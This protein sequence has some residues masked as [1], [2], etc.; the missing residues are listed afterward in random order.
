MLE[1][2]RYLGDPVSPCHQVVKQ[3]DRRADEKQDR[4][5]ESG[6]REGL[7]KGR[8]LS[9]H[10][11]S[12]ALWERRF[13]PS[14]DVKVIAP[15]RRPHRR[16]EEGRMGKLARLLDQSNEIGRVLRETDDLDLSVLKAQFRQVGVVGERLR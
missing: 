10:L 4:G 11:R 5:D 7:A 9:R 16:G 14:L 1:A 12:V 2:M 8:G 3:P 15:V 13:R 6:R